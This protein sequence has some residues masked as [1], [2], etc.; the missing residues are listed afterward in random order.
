MRVPA[1]AD[2]L[3]VAGWNN[4]AGSDDCVDCVLWFWIVGLDGKWEHAG[5]STRHYYEL[6]IVR[7]RK[8]AIASALPV[9]ATVTPS[10]LLDF[11]STDEALHNGLSVEMKMMMAM[12]EISGIN[13]ERAKS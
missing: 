3:K 10:G 7:D 5:W 4:R 11:A 6:F 8:E 2:D 12:M 13:D 1:N 9:G